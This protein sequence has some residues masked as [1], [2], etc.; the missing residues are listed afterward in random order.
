MSESWIEAMNETTFDS[1]RY[2]TSDGAFSMPRRKVAMG[3]AHKLYV[4]A[5]KSGASK[6]ELTRIA[7]FGNI[8]LSSRIEHCYDLK[9]AEND[10][11]IG[12]LEKKYQKEVYA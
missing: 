11:G 2:L 5:L 12:D 4:A 9:L 3:R 1:Q 10:F 8:V 6:E 7:T